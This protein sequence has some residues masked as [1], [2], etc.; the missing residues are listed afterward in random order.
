MIVRHPSSEL[1]HPLAAVYVKS[2]ESEAPTDDRHSDRQWMTDDGSS[3]FIRHP[4]SAHA[5]RMADGAFWCA[6]LLGAPEADGMD[7]PDVG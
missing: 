4:T 6:F 5:P 3:S 2:A 7:V 1:R